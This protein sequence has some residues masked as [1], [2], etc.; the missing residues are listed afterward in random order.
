MFDGEEGFV[1]EDGMEA[2][3]ISSKWRRCEAE[4]DSVKLVLLVGGVLSMSWRSSIP[5]GVARSKN[6]PSTR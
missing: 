3:G 2:M 4:G 5:R 6:S 1:S